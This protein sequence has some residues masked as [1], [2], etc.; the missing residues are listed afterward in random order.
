MGTE[1]V[2]EAT[3]APLV[4]VT[5]VVADRNPG[6]RQMCPMI[7]AMHLRIIQYQIERAR[8]KFQAEFLMLSRW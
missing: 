3:P 7:S 8:L 5:Q 1:G 6:S 2:V 4:G